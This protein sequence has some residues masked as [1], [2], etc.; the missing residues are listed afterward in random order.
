MLFLMTVPG[1]PC[2]YY[3]DEV[4]LDGGPDPDCRKAFP[5]SEA[6]WDHDLRRHVKRCIALRTEHAALRRGDFTR[7]LAQDGVYAF[8]RRHVDDVVIVVFNQTW[9]D[10]TVEL[11]LSAVS[12]EQAR[13]VEPWTG[14]EPG[15]VEGHIH[16]LTLGPRTSRV[17]C[18][19][20]G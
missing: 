12:S 9:E 15:I 8:A 3:G 18:Q 1:A 4:G 20:N 11:P 14:I 7:L 6:D 10:R 13:F 2:L 17:L 19:S 5:W 16:E